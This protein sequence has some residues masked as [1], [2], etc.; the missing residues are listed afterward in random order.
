VH[1]KFGDQVILNG[2]DLNVYRGEV[3]TVIG[4]SGGGKSVLLKH[5]IG[6]ITP[7]SGRILYEGRSID[8]MKRTME[9]TNSFRLR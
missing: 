5:V 7:D 9:D 1:K 4:K 8:D 6:L 3:L 2:V